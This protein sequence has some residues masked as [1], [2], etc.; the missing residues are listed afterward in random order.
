MR[1][2]TG[3]FSYFVTHTINKADNNLVGSLPSEMGFLENLNHMSLFGNKIS[4]SIPESFQFLQNLNFW[5]MNSNQIGGSVPSWINE[6]QALEYLALGENALSG[7]LPSFEG[8][9]LLELALDSNNLDGSIDNLD[10]AELLEVVYLNNNT[11]TGKLT[12]E[13]WVDLLNSELRIADLSNN[14]LTGSFPSY[15]YWLEE[16]DLSY[17][18]LAGTIAAPVDDNEQEDLPTTKINLAEN[19]LSGSIPTNIDILASLVSFD[20]SGNALVGSLPTQLGNLPLLESLYL[21][22][23]PKLTPGPIPDLSDCQSLTEVSMAST[24]RTGY[25][26]EWF[27]SALSDL[28]LL[29]LH[30]NQLQDSIPT[31]LGLLNSLSV[32]MLNRNKL[33]GTVPSELGVLE[34]LGTKRFTYQHRL[35]EYALNVVYELSFNRNS[36]FRP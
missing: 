26:P 29:D 22:N 14:Q 28:E 2:L 35:Y 6:L 32:L 16:I 13:T 17:N 15:F 11:F 18:N 36:F 24:Q 10:A 19:N 31:N 30:D 25:M 1:E 8:S 9:V 20:V 4:G 5:N 23:N 33:T 34:N 27:G 21:S 12:E 7:A 3:T